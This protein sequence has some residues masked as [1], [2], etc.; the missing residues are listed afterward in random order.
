M[1]LFKGWWCLRRIVLDFP[2]EIVKETAL[3]ST[4][5]PALGLAQDQVLFQGRNRLDY[6]VSLAHI[7]R[8][9]VS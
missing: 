4:L 9:A 6:F 3:P 2:E 7:V 8:Q 1:T 5:L